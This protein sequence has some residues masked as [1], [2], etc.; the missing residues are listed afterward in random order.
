MKSIPTTFRVWTNVSVEGQPEIEGRDEPEAQLQS[1]TPGYFR[2]LGIP[3]RRGREFTA[4]DNSADAP[5]VVII[6]E[7]F[8]HR[9]WPSYPAAL[10]PVGQ[11][12]GEGADMIG[13]AEIVGI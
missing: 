4:R 13:S 1:I 7:S 10:N 12:M 11:H 2:T 5:P 9:F 3:L 8:A 6:N